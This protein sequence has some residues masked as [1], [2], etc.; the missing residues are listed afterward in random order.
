MQSNKAARSARLSL[1]VHVQMC[2]I[3]THCHAALAKARINFGLSLPITFRTK[4]DRS[5]VAVLQQHYTVSLIGRIECTSRFL[6]G[7]RRSKKALT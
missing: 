6:R 1:Y 5:A 7:Q 4:P 2:G 3:S